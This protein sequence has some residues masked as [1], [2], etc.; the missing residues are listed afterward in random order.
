MNG[1]A[2]ETNSRFSASLSCTWY[3]CFFSLFI[4]MTKNSI[5]IARAMDPRNIS[6]TR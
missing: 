1:A 2:I 4:R 6:E 5:I 3:L